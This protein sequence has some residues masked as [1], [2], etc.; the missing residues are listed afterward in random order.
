VAAA[1][2][3]GGSIEDMSRQSG[4][5]IYEHEHSVERVR[6]AA[7]ATRALP[8]AFTLT[9]RAENYLVGRADIKDTIKQLQAYQEG[10]PMFSTRRALLAQTISLL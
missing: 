1:G 4:Y 10:A 5:P 9:A 6:A 8:F 2:V 3:V 7:E